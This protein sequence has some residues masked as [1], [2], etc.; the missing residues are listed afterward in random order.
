MLSKTKENKNKKNLGE[1][2]S[3]TK[4]PTTLSRKALKPEKPENRK[5]ETGK[6]RAAP[7]VHHNP[8]KNSEKLQ[9]KN[10]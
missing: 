6:S 3:R 7:H 5:T 1:N 4:A 8:F 9:H 10:K 2:N